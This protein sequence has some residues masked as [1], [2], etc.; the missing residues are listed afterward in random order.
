[1][2]EFASGER[3]GNAQVFATKDEARSSAEDRFRVWTMPTGYGVD[4]TADSV[5]YR[6]DSDE[7]DVR[8]TLEQEAA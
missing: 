7:G 4:E 5:T 2:F 8:L 3:L 1:M 6:W